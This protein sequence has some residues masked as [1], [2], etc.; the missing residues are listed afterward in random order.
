MRVC[1]IAKS[2]H[3]LIVSARLAR[4]SSVFVRVSTRRLD[5]LLGKAVTPM[6]GGGLARADPPKFF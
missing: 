3:T 5:A 6:E 4:L 2:R 1:A